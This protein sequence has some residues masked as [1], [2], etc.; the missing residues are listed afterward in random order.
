MSELILFIIHW[1][2]QDYVHVDQ[3]PTPNEERQRVI[4]VSSADRAD[5]VEQIISRLPEGTSL[6]PRQ[7]DI[8]EG[9]LDGKT[10]KEIAFDLHLSEN[11]VKMHTSALYKAIGVSHRDEI[12]AMLGSDKSD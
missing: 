4:I 6:S 9:I 5:R 10:R 12:Y 8:L 2:L 3:V 11:T 1:M 7:L